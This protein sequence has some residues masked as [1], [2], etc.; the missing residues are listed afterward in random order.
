MEQKFSGNMYNAVSNIRVATFRDA[1][2]K[3]TAEELRSLYNE[4][5]QYNSLCFKLGLYEDGSTEWSDFYCGNDKF[6]A[7]SDECFSAV[8]KGY[9][10]AVRDGDNFFVFKNDDDLK[11]YMVKEQVCRLFTEY[12]FAFRYDDDMNK[13]LLSVIFRK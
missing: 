4:L 2:N 1:L 9:K 11:T 8:M 13:F 5:I 3:M 7:I 10:W 12:S 6:G